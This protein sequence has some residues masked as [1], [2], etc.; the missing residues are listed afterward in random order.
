MILVVYAFSTSTSAFVSSP[1]LPF[2]SDLLPPPATATRLASLPLQQDTVL[3]F[4][5]HLVSKS[6]SNWDWILPPAGANEEIARGARGFPAPD[7]D[8]H[9]HDHDHVH[10]YDHD[11]YEDDDHDDHDED[12][13]GGGL[14]P[15]SL[16]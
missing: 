11:H 15:F 12:D 7:H 10:D 8:D 6:F 9:D 5:F 3:S 13:H 16:S 1:H 4:F 14:K 2:Q